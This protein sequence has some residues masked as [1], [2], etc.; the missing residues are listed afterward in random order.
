MFACTSGCPLGEPPQL[1]SHCWK[2]PELLL[3][4][5]VSPSQLGA[6]PSEALFSWAASAQPSG[7]APFPRGTLCVSHWAGL[8]LRLVPREGRQQRG[9]CCP[10]ASYALTTGPFPLLGAG[11]QEQL[12]GQG[13]R[14][15]ASAAAFVHLEGPGTGSPQ[16]QPAAHGTTR[17][18]R[19]GTPAPR[20]TAGRWVLALLFCCHF[21]GVQGCLVGFALP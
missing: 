5:R 12:R 8:A 19:A 13:V 15:P 16:G 9:W 21:G 2:L 11:R 20:L 4:I 14:S 18:S 1:G 7:A 10:V 3:W 17:Q 6:R